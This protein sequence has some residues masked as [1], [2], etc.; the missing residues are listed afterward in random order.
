MSNGWR[1]RRIRTS[2]NA[3]AEGIFFAR[4]P[5][6]CV[7]PP[8]KNRWPALTRRVLVVVGLALIVAGAAAYALQPERG[9]PSGAPTQDE[10]ARS[11]GTSVMDHVFLGHV[12]G[13]SGEI[14]LVPKP[15]RYL[16]GEWDLTTLDTNT[17]DFST[18]H[19]NPWDYLTRV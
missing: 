13:R 14:M 1:S 19:P 3:A 2:T 16:I 8:T 5:T 12:P 18:S 10:M 9:V 6:Y 15:H 11:I 7:V 4:R 17:P